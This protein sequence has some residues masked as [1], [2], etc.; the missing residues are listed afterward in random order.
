MSD[1]TNG[2]EAA[3]WGFHLLAGAL[4]WR[5]DAGRCPTEVDASDLDAELLRHGEDI[6]VTAAAQINDEHG[7]LRQCRG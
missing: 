1:K 2:L 6:L 7:A 3:S 4:P 5:V